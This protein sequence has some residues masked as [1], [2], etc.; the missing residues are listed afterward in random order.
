MDARQISPACG[1][2]KSGDPFHD[3]KLAS[4]DFQKEL[5]NLMVLA[6]LRHGEQRILARIRAV[7]GVGALLQQETNHLQMAFAHGEMHRRRVVVFAASQFW[8]S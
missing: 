5:G 7:G 2:E 4:Q 3:R 6:I 8:A 1:V